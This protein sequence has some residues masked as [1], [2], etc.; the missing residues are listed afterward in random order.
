MGGK[1]KQK[2][3]TWVLR[4]EHPFIGVHGA[5]PKILPAVAEEDG[6]NE[7]GGG[8][9][10]PVDC[11]GDP[12]FP[13]RKTICQPIAHVRIDE[14][15][16]QHQWLFGRWGRER[17]RRCVGLDIGDECFGIDTK[18]RQRPGNSISSAMHSTGPDDDV[19]VLSA[20]EVAGVGEVSEAEAK[21]RLDGLLQKDGSKHLADCDAVPLLEF[22]G[23]VDAVLRPV[24]LLIDIPEDERDEPV[25]CDREDE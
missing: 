3:D 2:R 9:E 11:F 16:K 25:C 12:D 14:R 23:G 20:L 5:M 8:L 10:D 1:G 6:E 17:H 24:V 18:K 13:R 22:F 15:T 7:P 19:V 4:T 21:S